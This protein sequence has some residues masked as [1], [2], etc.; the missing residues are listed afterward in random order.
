MDVYGYKN[1]IVPLFAP[2][3]SPIFESSYYNKWIGKER[4]GFV[5]AELAELDFD[6]EFNFG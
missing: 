6:G 4:G 1:M 2:L 5:D 3:S